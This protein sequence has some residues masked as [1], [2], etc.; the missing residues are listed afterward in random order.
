M[1][2]CCYGVEVAVLH[3]ARD[4]LGAF[5]GNLLPSLVEVSSGTK[6]Q[7]NT[8]KMTK[9]WMAGEPS[10]DPAFALRLLVVLGEPLYPLQFLLL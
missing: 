8:E 10:Q 9:G 5:T 7:K 3:H 6:S 2:S 4:I 1:G